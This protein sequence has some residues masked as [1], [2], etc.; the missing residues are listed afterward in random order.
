MLDENDSIHPRKAERKP[1]HGTAALRRS[2]YNKVAV[3]VLDLSTDGFRV[4]TFSGITVGAPVWITLPG[5][6]AI[7]AKV[8]WVRGDQ[9]G[10]RF[11][12]PLHPSVLEAVVARVA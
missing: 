9:L 6:S 2:G 8:M 1:V 10:C 5:L 11:I 7:E 3:T 12:T 4:E